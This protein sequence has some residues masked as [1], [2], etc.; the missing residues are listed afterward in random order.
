MRRPLVI[1]F[2]AAAAIAGALPAPGAAGAWSW[3][4]GGEVLRPFVFG[5]DPYAAGQHRGIDIAAREGESVLA[6]T[7]GTVT[8]SGTVPRHGKTVTIATADGHAVTLTHL[9]DLSSR[10]GDAVAEGAR[11]GTAGTSGDAEV[12]GPY[13]HLGIRVV[14][15]EH[16][17][18]D[19]LRFLPA[20]PSTVPPQ[21]AK[22]DAP[23]SS[24]AQPQP[25][26]A[27]PS[28]VASPPA[29]PPPPSSVSAP[30]PQPETR[31]TPAG[32]PAGAPTSATALVQVAS[33]D[34]PHGAGTASLEAPTAPETPLSSPG[35][36]SSTAGSR[37]AEPAE[38]A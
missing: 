33:P 28:S 13:L 31:P 36:A 7:A 4:V 19:P 20:R 22:G 32:Q 6:P 1:L 34:P 21:A 2:V 8:F 16:G 38:A 37:S 11:V 24:V 9:G 10:K 12:D 18:L 3:P 26:M 35:G 5:D 15:D 17:Y 30:A 25:A 29:S 23:P 27:P 14:T